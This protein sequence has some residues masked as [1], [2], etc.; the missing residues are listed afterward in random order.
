MKQSPFLAHR[1][2]LLNGYGAAI[3][4]R[5]ITL[6]LW[7]GRKWPA[8]MSRVAGL[9]EQHFAI[10][11]ELLA[12]YR[13]YG[14]N[15]PDFMEA[16]RD[17]EA[18]ALEAKRQSDKQKAYEGWEQRVIL[19]LRRNGKSGDLALDNYEWFFSRFEQGITPDLAAEQAISQGFFEKK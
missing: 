3:T 2:I 6:S 19:V 15:D 7:N 11:L 4:L 9:D 10:V 8:D 5:S 18:M 12:W 17:C 1:H 14:E 16:G 13:Q